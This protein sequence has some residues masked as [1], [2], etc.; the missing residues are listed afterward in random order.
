MTD[1]ERN[2]LA[3][4]MA[5]SESINNGNNPASAFIGQCKSSIRIIESLGYEII[6]KEH[7]KPLQDAFVLQQIRDG[8]FTPAKPN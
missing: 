8:N 2:K 7:L 1:T 6:K 4:I 3:D 5:I